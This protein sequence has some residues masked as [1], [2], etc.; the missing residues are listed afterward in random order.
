MMI[1]IYIYTL[2]YRAPLVPGSWVTEHHWFLGYQAPLVLGVPSTTGS[3]V[4]VLQGG[5]PRSQEG[6]SP[7]YKCT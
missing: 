3:R 1:Y 2:W 6:K 4:A 5:P 7:A